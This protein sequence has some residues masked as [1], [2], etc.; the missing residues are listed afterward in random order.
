MPTTADSQPVE[1][2]QSNLEPVGND[3][4]TES[5]AMPR[6]RSRRRQNR[7]NKVV[8]RICRQHLDDE[9]RRLCTAALMASPERLLPVE[10]LHD[11]VVVAYEMANNL[12][13]SI[14]DLLSA[15]RIAGSEDEPSSFS[16]FTDD[17][18]STDDGPP[19]A[20]ARAASSTSDS[21]ANTT[22]NA[23][24][25]GG[26]FASLA[27]TDVEAILAEM[28]I[29]YKGLRKFLKG[30]QP[31]IRAANELWK[32]D[33]SKS[34][35]YTAYLE[36]AIATPQID[37]VQPLSKKERKKLGVGKKQS[38]SEQQLEIAKLARDITDERRKL[39]SEGRYVAPTKEENKRPPDLSA[40]ALRALGAELRQ[41]YQVRITS[42]ASAASVVFIASNLFP[43]RL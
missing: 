5:K 29:V 3:R 36:P 20:A 24:I 39:T 35:P 18:F 6:P 38:V 26:P 2:I 22:Q 9:L 30:F 34:P 27:R 32:F 23:L 42:P 17:G 40:G 10:Q 43:T 28:P 41:A 13:E 33:L 7:P 25:R 4:K 15:L 16:E 37:D 1:T 19:P 8:E 21:D 31:T 11:E 12:P 14:D